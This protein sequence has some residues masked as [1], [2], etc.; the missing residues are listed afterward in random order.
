MIICNPQMK[1]FDSDV[2]TGVVGYSTMYSS[3]KKALK[4]L[5]HQM[6]EENG[7]ICVHFSAPFNLDKLVKAYPCKHRFFFTM[8]ESENFS[9]KLAK[10]LEKHT[11]AI[12]VPNKFNK[13]IFEDA[14]YKKPI[15]VIGLGIHEAFFKP[16]LRKYKEGEEFR[17]LHYNAGEPRKGWYS[18][19]HAFMEEFKDDTNVKLVCKS[20][21][22]HERQVNK[23]KSNLKPNL[24]HK[25]EVIS[26]LLPIDKLLELAYSCHGFVFPAI[27]EGYGLTPREM[28]ATGMPTIVTDGHSFEELPE[29]YIKT[30]IYK[31]KGSFAFRTDHSPISGL[32]Y[33]GDAYRDQV[34][35]YPDIADLRAKMRAVYNDY[36]VYAKDAYK[37]APKVA[38]NE[39]TIK[40]AEKF[41]KIL[42]NYV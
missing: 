28:L 24:Y 10:N 22:T 26:D 18:L 27:G 36:S 23:T 37:N 13:K 1:G 42:T 11:T 41:I 5:G 33:V 31:A 17:F 3:F 8:W 32:A 9:Q 30:K 34:M 7:E 39:Q 16:K 35:V 38:E 21:R 12:F 20:N 40:F 29:W 19:V 14:G 25:L 6:V 2:K 15:H 4:K